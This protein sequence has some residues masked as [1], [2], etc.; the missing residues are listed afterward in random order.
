MSAGWKD[1]V[2]R[3]IADKIIIVASGFEEV[4]V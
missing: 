3:R 4:V 2:Q 1:S